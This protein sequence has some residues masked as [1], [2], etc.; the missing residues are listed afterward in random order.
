VVR[1]PRAGPSAADIHPGAPKLTFQ[2]RAASGLTAAV[3]HAVSDS[4]RAMA[5]AAA[6][7]EDLHVRRLGI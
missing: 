5:G 6:D 3:L 2:A 4:G 7:V 1:R